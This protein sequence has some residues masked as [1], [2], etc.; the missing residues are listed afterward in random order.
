MAN[1]LTKGQKVIAFIERYCK[2]PEGALVGQPIKLL[3]FQKKFITDIYDNPHGTREAILSIGRKNGK[4]ALTAG[5]LLAH[6]AGP[7]A[8]LNS[9]IIAGAMSREQAAIIF[10]LACKMIRLSPE[11][12]GLIKIVPSSKQ[13]VGLAMNVTFK[14][15][16]AEGKTAHG[17]SPIVAIIDEAGQVV[18]SSSEFINAIVTA[19]G[20]HAEPLLIFISTQAANDTDFL[21]IKIDDALKSGDKHKVC[22]LYAADPEGDVLDPEQWRKANPALGVFLQEKYVAENAQQASR[23][24]SYENTFRNLMLNQR[25]SANTP[26]ISRDAWKACGQEPL[27]LDEC[28]AVYIG[29]DLSKRLDLTAYVMAGWHDATKTWNIHTRAFMPS[30]G[31][32]D[33]VKRDKAPYDV[34]AKEGH[35][36]LTPGNTIEY[37]LV[38]DSLRAD[39]ETFDNLQMVA[40][41]RWRMDIF[42]QELA[43]E[44]L[45]HLPLVQFGQGTKDM[46]PALDLVETAILNKKLVHGNNPVLTM[47]AANSV[48]V[49]DAAGGRKLDKTKTSGRIDAMVAMV[50][51]VGAS[52]MGN[53]EIKT[54]FNEAIFNPLILSL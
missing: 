2:V 39:I 19:Q 11:L 51:A 41:D 48:V 26:F 37:S 14:A 5:I 12:S 32:Q 52:A 49:S 29:L 16:S 15:I 6:I 30:V 27:P 50:M 4:S 38:V 23:V 40:F 13:L 54:D 44:G 1:Q 31:L 9:Q 36:T 46:T 24:P 47:C 35:I 25:I 7:L 8:K 22:H 18:G 28:D 34:W 53:R 17:L 33:R 45:D 10:E 3:D 43:R 20:A 42:K 21:S